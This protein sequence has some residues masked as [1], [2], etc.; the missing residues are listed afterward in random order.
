MRTAD[1][2][3]KGGTGVTKRSGSASVM[4]YQEANL[5]IR[6]VLEVL[7]YGRSKYDPNFGSYLL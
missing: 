4:C 7:T 5:M 2:D 6:I 1:P 3:G